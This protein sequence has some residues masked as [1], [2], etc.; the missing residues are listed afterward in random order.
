MSDAI[1]I[2]S[3]QPN[4]RPARSSA[5]GPDRISSRPEIPG[6]ASL[7]PA[8][9]RFHGCV[10]FQGV[11]RIEGA[12]DGPVHGEGWLEIGPAA[13]IRGDVRADE[14]LVAGRVEGDIVATRRVV[15]AATA[16]VRGDLDCSSL[17]MAEG[18]RLA[19]RCRTG[20]GSGS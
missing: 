11:A 17:S 20:R 7:I 1:L 9:A 4:P 10:A 14:I 6:N 12:L 18:A 13:A 5:P 16:D 15:L 19:G 8:G 2:T 3:Q